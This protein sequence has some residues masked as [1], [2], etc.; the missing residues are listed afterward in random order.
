MFFSIFFLVSDIKLNNNQTI[1][2]KIQRK[3]MIFK[4]LT[5]KPILFHKT[6]PILFKYTCIDKS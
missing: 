5:I 4:L 3:K 6:N 2:Y 1:I